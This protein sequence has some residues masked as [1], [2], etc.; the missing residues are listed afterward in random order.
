MEPLARRLLYPPI[1]P[2][3][4]GWLRV[5]SVHELYYEECGR[6]DGVPI[7]FLHGG[8]G[9][10]SDPRARR[11]FDPARY[12]IIVFDQRGAGRSRPHAS[13]VDNT[14]W[15]LVADLEQLRQFLGIRRWHV[16]G[17]SWGSLLALAYAQS[18]PSRVAGLVL[19][20]VFLGRREEVRWLNQ[21]GAS[22][23]FP[24]AWR[25]YSEHIPAEERSDYVAAYYRRLTSTDP[26]TVQAAARAWAAWEATTSY[27]LTNAEHVARWQDHH[28]AIAVARI[29]CHYIQHG[30]FLHTESQ[31]LDDLPRILAIPAYIVNGR[32]D[33]VCPV[34]A[35]Y[36]LHRAW[37][38]STLR[39]VADAG[40]AAFEDGTAHEL[41]CSTDALPDIPPSHR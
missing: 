1:E 13:L 37:P 26:G 34:R 2:Y 27:L 23:L 38:G 33:I 7:V 10:G 21:F 29:E 17:G 35:A 22:E 28:L 40:H 36:E 30:A 3:R 8:P 6:A 15:D 19:R 14:T 41:V 24:E 12:R 11:F 16:F 31:L 4:S 5:S 39:I 25:D 20:G 18:H 9:T 32:Y